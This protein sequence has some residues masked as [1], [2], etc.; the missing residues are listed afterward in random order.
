MQGFWSSPYL[1]VNSLELKYITRRVWL[2]QWYDPWVAHLILLIWSY[3]CAPA[4]MPPIYEGR[5]ILAGSNWF[6]ALICDSQSMEVRI[7]EFQ[8]LSSH[9]S[10]AVEGKKC[11]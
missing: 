5:C 7:L 6:S 2:H 10:A 8:R 4:L 9:L 1:C 11:D 3:T